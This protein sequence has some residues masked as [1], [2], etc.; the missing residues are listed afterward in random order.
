MDSAVYG[1]YSFIKK[2]NLAKLL[3]RVINSAYTLGKRS[4]YFGSRVV[5][6]KLPG[7]VGQCRI[8]RYGN[9]CIIRKNLGVYKSKSCY[10]TDSTSLRLFLVLSIIIQKS[11]KGVKLSCCI[12]ETYS[13]I[14]SVDF[15]N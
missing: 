12:Y 13:I 15:M 8:T 1:K 2:K 9:R 6:V 3:R 14:L 11:S 10:T 7:S 4:Y 5:C